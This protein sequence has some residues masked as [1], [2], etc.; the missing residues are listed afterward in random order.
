MAVEAPAGKLPRPQ[1]RSASASVSV[2]CLDAAVMSAAQL[3]GGSLLPLRGNAN[4][5][6]VE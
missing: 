1:N 5:S 3:T 2:M 6:T 4:V